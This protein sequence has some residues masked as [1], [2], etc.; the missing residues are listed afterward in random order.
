[1]REPSIELELSSTDRRVDLIREGFDCVVRVGSLVDSGL[2]AR[3]LGLMRI[4]NCVSPA[5]IARWG[6]PRSLEDLSRHRL[7]HYTPTLGAKPDGWEYRDGQRCAS[8]AMA[9]ALTVNNADAYLHACL[10]GLGIIQVPVAGVRA[11]LQA[12]ELVEVLQDFPIQPMP[13][14]LL[15]PHRRH[16]PRRVQVFMDWLAETDRKSTRLNSSH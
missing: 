12:G 10:A 11:Y 4:I 8:V 14:T 13:V 7:V 9:G 1:A 5:Y 16:L 15:H 3:P 6:R 2:T